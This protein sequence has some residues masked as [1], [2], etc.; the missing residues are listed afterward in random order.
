MFLR[1]S[2]NLNF[3]DTK[4]QQLCSNITKHLSKIS[5]YYPTQLLTHQTHGLVLA[6]IALHEYIMI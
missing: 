6:V 2:S 5:H 4:L 3:L 1:H